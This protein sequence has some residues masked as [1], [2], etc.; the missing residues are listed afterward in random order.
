MR[1]NRGRASGRPGEPDAAL[2]AGPGAIDVRNVSKFF[3]VAPDFIR[4]LDSVSVTIRE[5]EFFTLLGPSGCGKTTLLRLIAGFDFPTEGEILLYGENIA[6]LP[7]VQASGQHGVSELRPVSAHDGG[8]EHRL[9][10]GDARQAAAR[11]GRARRRHAEARAHGGAEASPDEPKSPA[12]SSSAWRSPA[13]W[14]RSPRCCCSTSPSRRS[15]TS[16]ART[17]RSSS[18]ACSTKPASPSFSS[19]TT[20][21]K[22]SPCRTASPSCRSGNI[23]QVGN[24]RDIYDRPAERFVANFIGE[25]N[26]LGRPGAEPVER[27]G[28]GEAR[29]RRHHPGHA[30]RR[31]HAHRRSERGRASRTRRRSSPTAR[32]RRSSGR[33]ENVVYFGTD[34]HFH[35][36]L[37]G[38]GEFIVRQQNSPQRRRRIHARRAGRHPD[39]PRCR[40]RCCEIEP[41][42]P[43]RARQP[44]AAER[45][46]VANRWYLV[47]AGPRHRHCGGRRPAADH[48]VLLASAERRLRQRGLELLA[49]TAGSTCCSSGTFSTTPCPSP[50]PTLSILWRS[51]KL[52]AADH[53]P[54]P[55]LRLSHRLFHHHPPRADARDVALPGDHSV[56]DQSSHPHLRH[57]GADPRRR[58]RSTTCCNGSG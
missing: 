19:P 1:R 56:L 51:V 18:S 21:K 49:P 6:P 22:R 12:A 36:R 26:F 41:R 20:R 14:P 55:D 45:Q 50:M 5:N 54:D 38:G 34:T 10:A 28:H 16:S 42:S 25:T 7:P 9:R 13:R 53:D 37:D 31:V 48:G 58:H 27:P 43:A 57:P 46:D 29:L 23:L 11:G 47:A 52:A 30:A 35:V 33:L 15:T 17:C 8:A 40:P 39:R 32:T 2:V 4:A 3:G 24:P 44:P